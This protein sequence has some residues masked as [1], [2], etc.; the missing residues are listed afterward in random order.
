MTDDSRS[1]RPGQN[2]EPD[3]RSVSA[4]GVFNR[5]PAPAKQAD[6]DA[7]NAA[8]GT[9]AADAADETG[10]NDTATDGGTSSE[11]T[12]EAATDNV[13]AQGVFDRG[14]YLTD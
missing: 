4:Q 11:R 3:R 5:G 2:R 8:D 10:R 9:A 14:G 13:T 12:S 7:A 1:E 6:S